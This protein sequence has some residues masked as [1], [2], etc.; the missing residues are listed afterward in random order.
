VISALVVNHGK[1]DLLAECLSS[2]EVALAA[3]PAGGELI[4]IDNGSSDGSVAMI[5][6]RHPKARLIELPEN[7]GFAPAVV[8]GTELAHGDWLALVNNDACVEPNALA[9]MLVAGESSGDVGLV[10]AQVRFADAPDR[11]NTAGLEIDKLAISYDRFA[12]CPVA[13]AAGE[14]PIEVFGASGCLSMYRVSMLRAVGGFDASFFAYM[15]DADLSWRA[16]MAGWR[17]LY[18]PRAIA[19]HHGSATLGEGTRLKYELVGRNRVRLIAKNATPAQLRRWGW[20]MVLYDVA[21]VMFVLLSDRTIAPARGRWHGLREWRTFRA[22]GAA[23]RRP[24]RLAGTR[25]WLAALRMRSAYRNGGTAPP[26]ASASGAPGLRRERL[27][28]MITLLRRRR[29]RFVTAYLGDLQGIEIGA[30]AHNRFYLNALNVDRWGTE[31]TVYKKYERR[32]GV[33]PATVHIVAPGDDLP[34]ENNSVDFVFS[35]H[36]IEHFPDPIR[37]LYEWIRVA[38]RYVVV[39]APHRDRTFDVDR[40]LTTVD[41]LL[42]RHR[43]GFTSDE[44]R[45]WS[46]WTCESFIELCERIG[47]DVLDRCDPDDKVGNGFAVVIDASSPCSPFEVGAVGDGRSAPAGSP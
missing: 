17:C 21:Y 32:V 25:G 38:R 14:K 16:R 47:L 29:S 45:H 10:T 9:L 44:D 36:V 37:A 5:R 28:T 33:K 31:D 40:P 41:E 24:V 12:G 35:S 26:T 19:Y 4:V 3:M 34:M 23:G 27:N 11:I 30:S 15:E 8:R 20:A 18:E 1:R 39:I 43:H 22:A 13:Q 7:E 46:V 42:T 2:V 6:E